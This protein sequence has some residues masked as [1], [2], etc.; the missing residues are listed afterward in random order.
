[1]MNLTPQQALNNYHACYDNDAYAAAADEIAW[2]LGAGNDLSDDALRK[3]PDYIALSNMLTNVAL[4]ICRHP[5]YNGEGWKL[6]TSLNAITEPRRQAGH[7]D[8]EAIQKMWHIIDGYL[9]IY[10]RHMTEFYDKL[11]TDVHAKATLHIETAWTL[12]EEAVRVASNVPDW[13]GRSTYHL[14]SAAEGIL[15]TATLMLAQ[16]SDEI[17]PLRFG[18]AAEKFGRAIRDLTYALTEIQPQLKGKSYFA[19]VR[20]T[21]SKLLEEV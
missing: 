3:T 4:E 17:S 16:K 15:R 7:V 12:T 1:M 10:R 21:L 13:N 5:A 9:G 20:E 18:Y 11:E 14:A 8:H 19:T 6:A 2:M